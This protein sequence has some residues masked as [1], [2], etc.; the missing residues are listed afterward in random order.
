MSRL[1]CVIIFMFS[2]CVNSQTKIDLESEKNQIQKDI[3]LIEAKISSNKKKKQ[4][5]VSD[6]E[7]LNFKIKL[8]ETLI[9]NINNQLNLI[10]DEVKLNQ[11]QL[12]ELDKTQTSLKNELSSMILKSYK[13]RSSLNRIMFI[14]SSNSFT[15]A[16]KRIQYFKQYAKFQKKTTEKIKRNSNLIKNNIKRLD[17]IKIEKKVLIEENESVRINLKIQYK[18]LNKFISEIN[19]NQK[20]F[21]DSIKVKQKISK[22]IEIK[23]QKIIADAYNNSKNNDGKI[24][25][26]EEAKV[27]SKNFNLNKGKLPWPVL[28]GYVILG[29][30]EQP[31]PVVKTATIQS[32]G[33]RIRTSKETN[34][35]VIFD[36]LVYSI[37]I[38][39]NNT[40]TVI[41][42]HGN[43]FSVYKNLTKIYVSKGD[44][45]YRKDI[46]GEIFTDAISKQTILS[47]SIFKDGKPQDPSQWI[48]KM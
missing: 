25:L 33:V 5:A 39:K 29:F 38:S 23:I 16:Y 36:G 12:A 1:F 30:G 4:L 3:R 15:Q 19:I 17:S 35:R 41:V 40:H 22:E 9:N 47:F 13:K 20:S 7:D 43:F 28:K 21:Q 8:Q 44:N 27:I 11:K 46:I 34:A 14:F 26:T 42:Q 18:D 6:V 48:Y 10:V 37:I 32:N 2:C 24:K 31:H 45:I